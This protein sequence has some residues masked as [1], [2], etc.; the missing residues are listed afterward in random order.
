MTIH[1]N[2]AEFTFDDQVEDYPEAWVEYDAAGIRA[3][4]TYRAVRPQSI[5]VEPN[6][7]VGTGT[8][9]FSFPVATDSACAVVIPRAARPV[10]ATAW[11]LCPPEGRSSA[12][13]VWCRARCAGCTE[14]TQPCSR[15]RGSCSVLPTTGKTQRCKAGHFNDFLFVS[16]V[17]AGFL[18]R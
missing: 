3:S 7:K 17:R 2:D 1:P 6:G 9:A 4:K 15:R 12:T 18:G 14:S 16:L 8:R 13:T 11:L 10:T 5:H